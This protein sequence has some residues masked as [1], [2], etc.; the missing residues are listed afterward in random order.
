MIGLVT[1]EST[2]VVNPY[3]NKPKK[4]R[5]TSQITPIQ[6]G[7]LSALALVACAIFGISGFLYF[8][9]T[10]N[11]VTVN[12]QDPQPQVDN[13]PTPTATPEP[14]ATPKF[15]PT[16]IPGW[17]KFEG[18]DVELW[19][20]AGYEG[21]DSVEN[22][23]MIAATIRSLGAGYE[24]VAQLLE[25]DPE[26]MPFFALDTENPGTTVNVTV[27]EIPAEVS[28]EEF[29]KEYVRA[30]EEQVFFKI[31]VTQQTVVTLDRYQAGQ[32]LLEVG[33]VEA[34]AP[35]FQLTYVIK[36]DNR[37]WAVNYGALPEQI[38]QQLPIFQQSIQ[39]FRIKS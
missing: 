36:E 37:V 32:L 11:T 4:K 38:G 3:L 17:T 27:R 6:I 7:I 15:T 8:S 9:L 25:Q 22:L 24:Q 30:L 10:S 28:L 1:S 5:Q 2:G 23:E 31:Q 18:G 26:A 21:G 13:T 12:Q 14:T 16:P 39:T 34:Q 35:N 33:T 20:P 29:M 19:L